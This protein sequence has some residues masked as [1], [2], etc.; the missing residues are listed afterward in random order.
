MERITKK[1]GGAPEGSCAED[2]LA[3]EFEK[4]SLELELGALKECEERCRRIVRRTVGGG[5]GPFWALLGYV[6]ERTRDYFNAIEAW[7]AALMVGGSPDL[8]DAI[9][10]ICLAVGDMQGAV[11]HSRAAASADP[12]KKESALLFGQVLQRAGRHQE[13]CAVLAQIL[14][15]QPLENAATEAAVHAALTIACK[16]LGQPEQAINHSA[17]A[18]KFDPCNK[19]IWI[20]RGDILCEEGLL[21]ESLDAYQTAQRLAPDDVNVMLRVA[22]LKISQGVL[23]EAR[24]LIEYAIQLRPGHRAARLLLGKI[25]ASQGCAIA[26][27]QYFQD[28]LKISPDDPEA[29]IALAMLHESHGHRD[30]AENMLD[31]CKDRLGDDPQVLSLCARLARDRVEREGI[32]RRIE[33]RFSDPRPLALSQ[34][35]H[36][37]YALAQILDRNAHYGKAFEN[38]V[39]GAACR[40]AFRQF[41]RAR[42]KQEFDFIKSVFTGS[43]MRNAP[44]APPEGPR[45]IFV[46]G[47]PRSGT[48]LVEQILASHPA[49]YG[50]GE[51][52]AL[53]Q[54]LHKRASG[55][56]KGLISYPQYVEN[57]GVE[58]LVAMARAY[59]DIVSAPAHGRE[60]ITD[61]LPSNFMHIGII[62]LMFPDAPIVY[63]RRDPR[64]VGLSCYLTDFAHGNSFSYDLSDCGWVYRQHSD[65]MAHWERVLDNP[66]FDLSYEALVTAPETTV[67]SLLEH[68]G[69]IWNDACLHFYK[70]PR[71][72]HTASYKQVREPIYTRSMGRWRHYAE[73]LGPLLAELG[74]LVPNDMSM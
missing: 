67:R 34:R 19:E 28:V 73:F 45:M 17:K 74:D 39:Q 55:A 15:S 70:N 60:F 69:L 13:A 56:A 59:R 37:H 66:V 23:G 18:I 26:A 7:R 33:A 12:E 49:V 42:S 27:E 29:L 62:R 38:A 31:Q 22:S 21:Q 25:V 24:Q 61:K 3:A 72:V 8:H 54:V 46:V 71:V 35:A 64:D 52:E 50:G 57:L 58:D 68:C 32:I 9:G 2:Y 43:A 6:Y 36:L 1:Y 30:I 53:G 65:L 44:R 5:A 51:S 14:D 63:C 16:I 10:R 48:S 40:K 4:A 11:A 47:M 41:D 20:L